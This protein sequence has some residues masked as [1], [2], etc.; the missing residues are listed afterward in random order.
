M[1]DRDEWS[2]RV[3]GNP[4]WQDNIMM[5]RYVYDDDDDDDDDVDYCSGNHN[6]KTNIRQNKSEEMT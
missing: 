6:K 1:D 4:C 2:E 5:K 3:K